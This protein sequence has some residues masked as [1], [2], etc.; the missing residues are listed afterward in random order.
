VLR[1]ACRAQIELEEEW[2][3]ARAAELDLKPPS[4][5]FPMRLNQFLACRIEEV[6]R[7]SL[8]QTTPWTMMMMTM[9]MMKKKR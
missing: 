6:M 1:R 4:L 7:R 8:S 2:E 9:K 5:V 3:K